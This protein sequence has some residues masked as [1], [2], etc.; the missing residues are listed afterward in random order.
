MKTAGCEA[1]RLS[2]WAGLSELGLLFRPEHLLAG[3]RWRARLRTGEHG[4][5]VGTCARLANDERHERDGCAHKDDSRPGGEAGEH[6]GSSARTKS[7][8]RALATEGA[9]KIG[10]AALLKQD[11]ADDEEAHDDVQDDYEVKQDL[12]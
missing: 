10:R 5:G 9:G 6:V 7:G 11:D 8:L 3:L 1:C 12:H 4:V 2:E